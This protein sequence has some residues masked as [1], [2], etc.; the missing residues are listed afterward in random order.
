VQRR[1]VEAV[2]VGWKEAAEWAV[3]KT[4]AAAG[5]LWMEPGARPVEEV[6][7]WRQNEA[8]VEEAAENRRT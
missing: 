7:E 4:K 1:L 5:P 3:L 6:V 2:A 8:P